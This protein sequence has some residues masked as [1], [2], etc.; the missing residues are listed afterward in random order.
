MIR[1]I[2]SHQNTLFGRSVVWVHGVDLEVAQLGHFAL[3]DAFVL[4]AFV[5]AGT[6]RERGH[7]GCEGNEL[8]RGDNHVEYLNRAQQHYLTS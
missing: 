6:G 3:G 2:Y 5:A 4:D 7:D 1:E 8:L